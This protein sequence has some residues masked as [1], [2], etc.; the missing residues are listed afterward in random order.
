MRGIIQLIKIIL[1]FVVCQAILAAEGDWEFIS[2][3]AGIAL[4]SREVSGHSELEFKAVGLVNQPLEVIG[5]VLSDISSYPKWF[6]K[7]IESKKIPIENTSELVYYLY[8]AIDTPWPF[9]NRDVVYKTNVIINDVV[10]K[11]VIRSTAL[12][13][14][15]IPP[16]RDFVRIIDSEHQWILESVSGQRTRISFIHRTNAAGSF[17]NYISDPGTRDTT[18]H[19]LKNLIDRVTDP[20]YGKAGKN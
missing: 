15:L 2:D 16:R 13:E 7:C 1:I 10:G 20:S 6:F 8:I 5:A 17:A 3:D 11:V 19:S 9:Y 14:Q 18:L 4:Y 12:T